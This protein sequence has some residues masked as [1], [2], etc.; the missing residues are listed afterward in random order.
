MPNIDV[1]SEGKY[2]IET[3]G[4]VKTGT[5][6]KT[7]KAY[8]TFDLQFEGDPQWYNCFWTRPEDPKIGQELDGKKEFNKDFDSHQFNMGF[9]GNKANWNPA[10]ANATV[11]AAAVAVVN[12]FLGLDGAHLD[13]WQKERKEGQTAIAHYLETV[14]SVADD[15]K[16]RVAK[17]GG[18][19]QTAA[20]TAAAPP[21]GGDPGPVS[22]GEEDW[23]DKDGEEEVD[24]GGM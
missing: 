13:K 16:Q 1:I 23:P 11:F 15:I 3:V 17:M 9:A 2:K 19:V 21:K 22:P 20:K 18:D 6:K 8:K 7:G 5:S 24:L 14:T 12:G 4:P 10:G